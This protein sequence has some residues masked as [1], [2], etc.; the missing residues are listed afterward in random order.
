MTITDVTTQPTDAER[1]D[2][3][4]QAQRA[5]Y[6]P[7]GGVGAGGVGRYHGIEG[8]RTLSH[9]RS[10]H[11]QARVYARFGKRTAVLLNLFLR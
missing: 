1:F 2:H 5:A 7:F 3:I 4:R 10:S 8:W 9:A 6:L 11:V